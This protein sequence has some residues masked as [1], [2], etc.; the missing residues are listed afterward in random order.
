MADLRETGESMW[1][2]C[3][4]AGCL[5]GWHIPYREDVDMYYT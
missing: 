2:H 1:N 3:S 5:W 4:A